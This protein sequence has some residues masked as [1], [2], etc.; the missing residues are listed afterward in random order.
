MDIQM[1]GEDART[2]LDVGDM[3]KFKPGCVVYIVATCNK[4]YLSRYIQLT[5]LGAGA[6][7]AT[8]IQINTLHRLK[9]TSPLLVE[10][11]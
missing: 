5:G 1:K 11:A 3:F 10:V 2:V 4:T 9:Q 6:I 7:Y 8:V